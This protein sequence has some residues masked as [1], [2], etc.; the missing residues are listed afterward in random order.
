MSTTSLLSARGLRKTFRR[1]ETRFAAL[2]GVDLDI[3]E[4]ETLAL[5]GP[6]G[7]G[8]STLS[9]IVMRILDADAGSLHF[10][11]RDLLATRGAALRALRRDLQMVFQDP[12]AA[13]NPRATVARVLDDP[14]R[15]HGIASRPQRPKAVAALLDRVGLPVDLIGRRIHE[16][17]GGQRQRVAIARALASMPKLIVLDEAL[18]AL[19]VSVRAGI[20]DLLIELQR[21]H[22]IAYL[23]I[24]HDLA[25]VRNI[26]DRVAIMDHGRIVETGH[27][28]AV[29]TAPRSDMGKALI[30][31][32]MTLPRRQ[33]EE[34]TR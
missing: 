6:S 21:E 30:A 23:F 15:I 2:D 24:S 16:I 18:S 26:A 31:A 7:S 8:K 13:F 1:G 25:V 22:G 14:L 27:P 4:G 19:D 10:A 34:I 3:A 9:R 12:L 11:G 28:D 5:V 32:A 17:S 33:M 20:I 29:L